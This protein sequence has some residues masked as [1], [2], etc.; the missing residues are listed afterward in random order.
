[1]DKQK[2]DKGNYTGPDKGMNKGMSKRKKD[3]RPL[4]VRCPNC[5]QIREPD[6]NETTHRY[7]CPVC[8]APVDSQVHIEMK[9]RGMK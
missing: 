6:L 7:V 1:M 2:K 8:S 3:E 4:A 5:R 9:K